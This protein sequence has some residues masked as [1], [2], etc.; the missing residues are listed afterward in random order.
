MILKEVELSAARNCFLCQRLRRE[1]PLRFR[2]S[3]LDGRWF[4]VRVDKWDHYYF[5][6]LEFCRNRGGLHGD[7]AV[8]IWLISGI[9]G[10]IPADDFTP[11]RETSEDPLSCLTLVNNWIE[12]CANTH[13]ACA[14]T[15]TSMPTRLLNV[16]SEEP[17]LE[18]S[19]GLPTTRYAAFSHCWGAEP[20]TIT[21]KRSL[22]LRLQNIPMSSL[23]RSFQ[24][25]AIVTRKLGLSHL[26]IDSLCIIQDSEDDWAIESSKMQQYYQ[27]AFLTISALSA[28]GS[29]DGFLKPRAPKPVFKLDQENL[30]LRTQYPDWDNVMKQSPLAKRGWILQEQLLSA[31]ILHFGKDELFWECQTCSKRESNITEQEAR[32]FVFLRGRLWKP[33]L[34]DIQNLPISPFEAIT[35]WFIVVQEYSRRNLTK[36]D[37]KLPAI[38]GLASLVQKATGYKYLAGLWEEEIKRSLLWEKDWSFG[39]KLAPDFRTLSPPLTRAQTQP[40]GYLAP[41]WSWVSADGPVYFSM[42]RLET[43]YPSGKLDMEL[44]TSYTSARSLNPL[45]Q[46][47]AGSIRLRAWTKAASYRTNLSLSETTVDIYMHTHVIIPR[48]FTIDKQRKKVEY[49]VGHAT[50]DDLSMQK[51]R[52]DYTL[53]RITE[54]LPESGWIDG[55]DIYC[56][57]ITEDKRRSG[58]WKRVGLAKIMASILKYPLLE[59][60]GGGQ[61]EPYAFSDW[62]WRELELV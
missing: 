7:Y 61:I 33:I 17:F 13:E 40:S 62:E 9:G 37:D 44:I 27:N 43:P 15:S 38:S 14:S 26:W 45:G 56:L 52:G 10:V 34:S 23:S 42:A 50:L 58:S 24:D 11:F 35:R 60:A 20:A 48:K 28:A 4:L 59:W 36:R 2:F 54:L 57:M 51:D 49:K 16:S 22:E 29:H 39:R 1:Y 3:L 6:Y 25:A 5:E 53:I 31:R 12:V 30:Y 18:L 47:T 21:T 8:A 55:P 41:T 19:E 46:V 32:E